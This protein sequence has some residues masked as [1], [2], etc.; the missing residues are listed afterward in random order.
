MGIRNGAQYLASLKDE[1]HVIYDGKRIVDVASEPGFELTARAVAQFYDFQ[2]APENR[3]LMTYVTEDGDRAG[4]AFKQARTKED[5]RQ[6][7]AAYAAW[8]EVT[9]GFMDRSPDYMNTLLAVMNGVSTSLSA[10]DPKLGERARNIYLDARRRDLFFS[11]TLAEPYKVVSA[12]GTDE[13]PACRVIRETADG[14]VVRGARALATLAPFANMNFDIGNGTFYQKGDEIYLCGFVVPVGH[15]GVQWICRD[16]LNGDRPHSESPLAAR[17]DEMDCV[18]LFDDCL[19]P[20][21]L[22]YALIPITADVPGTRNVLAGQQ[23]QVLVRSI[24]K[25]RFLLGLGHLIAES[26]K[27]NRFIN[28]QERLGE[29]VVWQRTLEAFAVAAV[30]N[31]VFD[32]ATQTWGPNPETVEIAGVWSAQY[33]PKMVG[34]ILE[35]GGSRHV[36]TPQQSTLDLLGE[37][38]ERYYAG[39]GPNAKENIALFRLAWDVAGSTWGSRQDLYERFHFGDATLRKVGAYMS[40]DLSEAVAMVRRILQV[41]PSRDQVFPTP[42]KRSTR[43]H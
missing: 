35:L 38:A 5:L 39:A 33:F 42:D 36:S 15:R 11:Q 37:L 14:I 41:P 16:K 4:M 17:I 1:R 8:A 2:S 10:I 20:W 23:H 29:L 31:A 40:T 19:I 34:H 30:E 24:A 43:T 7:A 27:V 28:V 12:P 25:A 21:E 26:S 22:V 18:L 3:E 32:Q 13:Q 9:C 6:R